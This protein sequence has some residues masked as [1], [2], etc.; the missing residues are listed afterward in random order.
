MF[1]R[2]REDGPKVAKLLARAFESSAPD[3][4][5]L[6][7]RPQLEASILAGPTGPDGD[8][9]R[10]LAEEVLAG[11]QFIPAP[12]PDDI[13]FVREYPLLPLA[14]LPQLGPNAREAYDAQVLADQSPHTRA[15]VPWAAP[16]PPAVA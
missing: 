9:F 13:V 5:T 12:L 8:R 15:D 1:F 2:Y 16:A 6:S 4:T 11:V 10:Q 3:L 7:G 14:D